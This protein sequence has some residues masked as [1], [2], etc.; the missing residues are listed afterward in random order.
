MDA[1][2]LSSYCL[3]YSSAAV[4]ATEVAVAAET[5]AAAVAAMTTVAVAANLS[6]KAAVLI[7]QQPFIFWVN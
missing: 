4:M 5:A 7:A 3:S 1:A 2:G 6:K